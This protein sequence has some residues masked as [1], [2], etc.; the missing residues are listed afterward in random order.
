[1]NKN[2]SLLKSQKGAVQLL[3]LVAAIAVIGFLGLSS[4]APFRDKLLSVLN[5]KPDSFAQ[6]TRTEYLVK[7]Y[8]VYPAD[9]P[10][11][12]EYETAVKNYLVELQNWYKEK[13]GKTGS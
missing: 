1:M 2:L 10:K 13:A 6:A 8:L 11:Y 5:R 9:K 3:L 12:P 4:T 7:P